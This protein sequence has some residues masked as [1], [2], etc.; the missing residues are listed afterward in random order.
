MFD[1]EI[2]KWEEIHCVDEHS[3][4]EQIHYETTTHRVLFYDEL[5]QLYGQLL[6][7]FRQ[8]G[9]ELMAVGI[10]GKIRR[11]LPDD[12]TRLV[13]TFME[14]DPD[15]TFQYNNIEEHPQP[16]WKKSMINDHILPED[17]KA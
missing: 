1:N 2:Q 8:S 6:D 3:E 7:L 4:Q 11:D 10:A 12:D 17:R 16:N 14:C 13:A 5:D 9:F 15:E